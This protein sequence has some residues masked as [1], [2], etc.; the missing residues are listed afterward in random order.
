MTKSSLATV[1]A[2]VAAMAVTG[3]AVS[4]MIRPTS[5]DATK[6]HRALESSD[7][8]LF[9]CGMHPHVVQQGPGQCPICGMDLTPI[10]TGPPVQDGPGHV[11]VR[12]N[13][14]FLQNFAVRTT[15]VERSDL[16]AQIRTIGYLDQDE[17]RL[18]SVHT[19][20][21]GWIEKSRVNTI[22][23]RVA[24]GDIL[25]EVYS[26]E[27]V[28][29]QEEYLL[30]IDHVKRLQEK[31]A[32]PGAVRRAEALADAATERLHHWDL[33]NRQIRDL[34]TSGEASRTVEVYSP[35]SGYVIE[36]L[37]DSLE[38]VLA[39]PGAVILKI[40]DQSTLWAK[41]E[42]FEHHLRNLREGLQADIS[43]DAFPGRRWAGR[44]LFFQP[45]VNSQTQTL[46]GYVEVENS[47]GRLRPKM[48]AT[49]EIQLPGVTDALIVPTQS[50]LRAGGNQNIV[51]VESGDGLF[52]P[53]KVTLGL[54][55]EG[56]VQVVAGLVAGERVVTSSQF[57]LDSE[58]NLQAA[59][60]RL[61][62][63]GA[64]GHPADH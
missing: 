6:E 22:G 30:A 55:S 5:G 56:Q 13:R 20:F 29:A 4:Y 39:S 45:T 7:A 14:N 40:A 47:D 35:A 1:V 44:L 15:V 61:A 54:E 2:T 18:V 37:Q 63:D 25:F 31:G 42:F 38:G 32:Y 59:V 26:P 60:E 62:S 52:I 23:E 46:T 43:L 51:I 41:V 58:S 9:T 27:L 8:S 57:L 16:P 11:G 48:Y 64:G 49:V 10:A 28:A 33:T 3:I 36:T 21:P 50:V 24:T 34:R 53:R 12:V 17:A 19:K